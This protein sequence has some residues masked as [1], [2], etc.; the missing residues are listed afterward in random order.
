MNAAAAAAAAEANK[1]VSAEFSQKE[2]RQFR[3]KAPKPGQKRF[4]NGLPGT[5]EFDDAAVICPWED[6]GEEDL[7]NLAQF[8]II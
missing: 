3:S 4:D 8:G 5:E 1:V 6:F 2:G 7:S